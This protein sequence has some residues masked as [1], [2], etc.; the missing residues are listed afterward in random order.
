MMDNFARYNDLGIE[1][2][3]TELDINCNCN[4]DF[5]SDVAKKQGEM[6]R[7]I[8]KACL[9]SPN[10]KNFETWGYT[11]KYTWLGSSAYPLP[12]D[13]SLNPKDAAYDILNT[14]LNKSSIANVVPN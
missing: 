7:T 13:T 6:Y 8:L 9:D 10:C 12:F 14:L 5:T 4:G 1:V 2:H 3:I 11:D